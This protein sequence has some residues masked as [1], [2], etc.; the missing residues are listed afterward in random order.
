MPAGIFVGKTTP[1]YQQSHHRSGAATQHTIHMMNVNK[2]VPFQ[3]VA[4]ISTRGLSQ[5]RTKGLNMN[6]NV[7]LTEP[8]ITEWLKHIQEVNNKQEDIIKTGREF[9]IPF[10]AIPMT[11]V[12]KV[13]II[14]DSFAL[15]PRTKYLS[16][17]I[18]E[19]F[20]CNQ[21]WE[22]YKEHET[23][24]DSE[25]YK[26]AC[27]RVSKMLMLRLMSSIQLASKM[28]SHMLGLTITQVLSALDRLEPN[29]QFNRFAVV[30]SEMKVF[31]TTN[32]KIPLVT[33][34]DCIEVLLAALKLDKL[35]K[36]YNTAVHI[37]DMT[38][39]QHQQLFSQL[40]LTSHSSLAKTKEDKV[41]FMAMESDMLFL[42]AAVIRCTMAIFRAKE[43]L[44]NDLVRRLE[45]LVKIDRKDIDNLGK[46]I[47][48]MLDVDN[49]S[50]N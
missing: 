42:S 33:P 10:M 22:I 9:Y 28:D 45:G 4:A 35:P 36:V 30:Q 20:V 11:V 18:Y 1:P 47:F 50:D 15:G 24:P 14:A 41:N 7:T 3:L 38:Y 39:L 27:E 48:A 8:L 37:L 40:Q 17:Y 49:V 21:F 2:R 32:F 13:F 29:H 43:V 46:M 31:Q 16:L 25:E 6:R 23:H 19:K 44:L 34:L 12:E 26:R 5:P